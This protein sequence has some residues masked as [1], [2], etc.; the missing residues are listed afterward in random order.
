[1]G[2][3]DSVYESVGKR[4]SSLHVFTVVV[5]QCSSESV[6]LCMRGCVSTYLKGGQC[7]PPM[8]CLFPQ[9]KE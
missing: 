1:M 4:H 2:V 5:G 8:S 9:I 7:S 6:R 3:Y